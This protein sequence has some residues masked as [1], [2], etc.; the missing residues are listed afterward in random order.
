MGV[1]CFV[2]LILVDVNTPH[3][4]HYLS[5]QVLTSFIL[6]DLL[7]WK[8][9]SAAL[10][11]VRFYWSYFFQSCVLAALIDYI[12]GSQLGFFGGGARGPTVSS[13][14]PTEIYTLAGNGVHAWCSG[15]RTMPCLYYVCPIDLIG[16][17]SIFT[18]N[19]VW[20]RTYAAGPCIFVQGADWHLCMMAGLL[21]SNLWAD[22]LCPWNV[23]L[24]SVLLSRYKCDY[25]IWRPHMGYPIPTDKCWR[26]C[27]AFTIHVSRWWIGALLCCEEGCLH[28]DVVYIYIGMTCHIY[29]EPLCS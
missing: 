3:C 20:F 13:N 26:F 5:G 2:S 4:P 10:W 18:V 1:V 7:E 16:K 25:L 22:W 8:N 14:F 27:G 19:L 21:T 28:N 24:L 12:V 9:Y 17:V 6:E 11:V 15:L 29:T 23:D